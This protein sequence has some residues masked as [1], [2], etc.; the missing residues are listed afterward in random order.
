MVALTTIAKTAAAEKDVVTFEAVGMVDEVVGTIGIPEAVA[1][2]GTA[3]AE[4]DVDIVVEEEGA[5][6]E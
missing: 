3:V 2:E 1:E 5:I 6:D 4:E